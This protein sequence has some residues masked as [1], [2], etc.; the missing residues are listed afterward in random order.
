[1]RVTNWNW[2]MALYVLRLFFFRKIY[3][4]KLPWKFCHE[5][6]GPRAYAITPIRPLS[7]LPFLNYLAKKKK[8]IYITIQLSSYVHSK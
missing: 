2:M 7:T 6:C 8:G 1:M 5:P 3:V 4:L